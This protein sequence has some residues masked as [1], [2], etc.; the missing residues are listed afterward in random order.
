[1]TSYASSNGGIDKGHKFILTCVNYFTRKVWLRAMKKQTA[2][3]VT[4]AMKSIVAETHTYPNIIQADNGTEF[5]GQ[6]TAWMNENNIV[7]IKTLSYTPTANGLV[8]GKNKIIRKTLREIMIRNN[9]QNWVN[10]LQICSNNMNSQ[11]NGT[12]K[13]TPDSLWKEVTRY[14]EKKMRVLSNCIKKES[15]EKFKEIQQKSI[16]SVIMYE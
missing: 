13:Q 9:S 2:K 12:I 6:T 7:Y 1:M 14:K 8:E 3:N 16:K 15:R 4:I 11:R 5:M 10:Y